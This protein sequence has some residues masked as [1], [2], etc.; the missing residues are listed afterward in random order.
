MRLPSI[1]DAG[2]LNAKKILQKTSMCSKE[3]HKLHFVSVMAWQLP[4]G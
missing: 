1:A 4:H 2:C 3:G